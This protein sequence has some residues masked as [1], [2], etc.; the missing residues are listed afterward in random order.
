M[1]PNAVP[2]IN[3]VFSLDP[4]DDHFRT[5]EYDEDIPTDGFI[6]NNIIP[7]A[8]KLFDF[9]PPQYPPVMEE[10]QPVEEDDIDWSDNGAP[11]IDIKWKR[12]MSTQMMRMTVKLILPIL[13]PIR[14]PS[15]LILLC[16]QLPLSLGR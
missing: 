8:D 12:F 4:N 2:Y 9:L 3:N 16:Q 5:M 1:L 15:R 13:I 6:H 7:V 11:A 14:Y 10:F